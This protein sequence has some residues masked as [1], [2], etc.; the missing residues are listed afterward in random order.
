MLY[1]IALDVLNSL[2]PHAFYIHNKFQVVGNPKAKHK[3]KEQS[4][5]DNTDSSDEEASSSD[6]DDAQEKGENKSDNEEEDMDHDGEESGVG[7]EEIP[8]TPTDV[9]AK[10][11]FL[12]VE[13]DVRDISITDIKEF[14]EKL[15]LYQVTKLC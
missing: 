2:I 9:P 1:R 4:E 15:K 10:L 14:K 6:E 5:D 8:E 7:D 12:P 13:E 11:T 3:L